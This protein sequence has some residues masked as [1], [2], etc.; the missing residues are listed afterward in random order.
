MNDI[1][2]QCKEEFEIMNQM[3]ILSERIINEAQNKEYN[4]ELLKQIF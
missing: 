2:S 1:Q 3:K 4:E